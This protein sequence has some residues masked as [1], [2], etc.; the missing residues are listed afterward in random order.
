MNVCLAKERGDK[1]VQ[2]TE[3]ACARCTHSIQQGAEKTRLSF[4]MAG[5][6]LSPS[7]L[8]QNKSKCMFEI[9]AQSGLKVEMKLK[10]IR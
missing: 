6:T 8:C 3:R 2:G 9:Q 5:L 4:N 10:L 7:L 1:S